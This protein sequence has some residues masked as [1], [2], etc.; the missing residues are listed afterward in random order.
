MKITK[1]DLKYIYIGIAIGVLWS[2]ANVALAANPVVSSPCDPA[3]CN[4]TN[5]GS[6][7]GLI[8]F[9]KSDLQ[10]TGLS[11]CSTFGCGSTASHN[12]NTNNGGITVNDCFD[13][14]LQPSKTYYI[15]VDNS[16]CN[17]SVGDDRGGCT[18]ASAT[19]TTLS[20]CDLGK[21]Y[22]TTTLGCSIDKISG[23]NYDYFT[24]LIKK[25][26]PYLLGGLLLLG[27]LWF[28]YKITKKL[29]SY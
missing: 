1:S 6:A 27:V 5:G 22:S 2:V 16:S 19:F 8:L 23:L 18:G 28:I 20:V 14:V 26:W 15:Y 4:L 25:F 12:C 13:V 24:L 9:E 29:Y 17:W 3:T 21:R 10:T 7:F 11:N